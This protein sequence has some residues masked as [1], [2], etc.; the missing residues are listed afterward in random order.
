MNTLPWE[1]VTEDGVELVSKSNPTK[2]RSPATVLDVNES[3]S[4]SV[5]ADPLEVAAL[6]CTNEI[7]FAVLFTVTL[8]AALVAV[9]PEE[10]LATATIV[11]IAFVRDVVLRE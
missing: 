2:M 10:S 8:T 9:F 11:C 7:G 3:A 5:F 1:S 6:A 4:E